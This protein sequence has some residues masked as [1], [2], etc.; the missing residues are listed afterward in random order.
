M[1]KRVGFESDRVGFGAFIEL[2]ISGYRS[3]RG[4]IDAEAVQYLRVRF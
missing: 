4:C 3:G 2:A 1:N